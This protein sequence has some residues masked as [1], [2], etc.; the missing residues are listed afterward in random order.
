MR[1]RYTT[2]RK[3]IPGR[4]CFEGWEMRKERLPVGLP[5]RRKILCSGSVVEKA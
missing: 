5:C 2:T 3:N 1:R 4:V